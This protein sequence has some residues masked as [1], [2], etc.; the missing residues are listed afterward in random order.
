MEAFKC[1]SLSK[2]DFEQGIDLGIYQ[3]C[4]AETTK[5]DLGCI[6]AY[7]LYPRKSFSSKAETMLPFSL[8]YV[9]QAP[10]GSKASKQGIIIDILAS[11]W[12]PLDAYTDTSILLDTNNG[13]VL[14]YCP[15]GETFLRST[16]KKEPLLLQVS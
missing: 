5:C 15:V 4:T 11:D 13:H 6:A 16:S 7:P 12:L 8:S 14:L 10:S 1:F 9:T 3:D 2:S